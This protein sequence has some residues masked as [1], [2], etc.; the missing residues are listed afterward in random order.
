ML[1]Q[2]LSTASLIVGLKP[3]IKKIEAHYGVK[4]IIYSSSNFYSAWL[5]KEFGDYPLWVANYNPGKE[6]IKGKKWKFW[7]YSQ[8]GK[9][10]GVK[11]PVDLDV[12]Y[13]NVNDLK[14]LCLK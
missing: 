14:K 12:F 10:E 9:I 5:K 3:W 8:W 6:P 1:C 2:I 13:G 7:Q 11:G 4:P